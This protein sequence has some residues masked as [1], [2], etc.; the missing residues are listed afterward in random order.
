MLIFGLFLHMSCF[1]LF[2]SV[3]EHPEADT[4]DVSG[5]SGGTSDVLV[6]HRPSRLAQSNV[7]FLGL[8]LVIITCLYAYVLCK[9][10]QNAYI[11][12]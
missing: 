7:L 5:D 10:I 1:F 9:K 12:L 6:G 3:S 11:A 2:L 4:E 8:K